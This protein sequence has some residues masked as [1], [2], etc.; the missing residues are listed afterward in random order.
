MF[1][2]N[3]FLLLV[4]SCFWAHAGWTQEL[5]F[6]SEP[7]RY[8]DKIEEPQA[9]GKGTTQ[10]GTGSEAAQKRKFELHGMI[11]TQ[12]RYNNVTGGTAGSLKDEGLFHA[13]TLRLDLEAEVAENTYLRVEAIGSFDNQASAAASE[14]NLDFFNC[15]FFRPEVFDFQVGDIRPYLSYFTL[16]RSL[17]GGMGSYRFSLGGE[18]AL[19]IM[20]VG[21]QVPM[22][23]G[24]GAHRTVTGYR[25]EGQE[26]LPGLV[27]GIDQ[28]FIDDRDDTLPETDVSVVSLNGHWDIPYIKNA[29]MYWDLAHS[30]NLQDSGANV[31]SRQDGWAVRWGA[32]YAPVERSQLMVEY[33]EASHDFTSPLASG[34]PD[35][36]MV[37]FNGSYTIFDNLDAGAGYTFVRNNL[38]GQ[39]DQAT[40]SHQPFTFVAYRPFHQHTAE[41]LANL[42]L[43]QHIIYTKR[44]DNT[45]DS[46]LWDFSWSIGTR[47]G[48]LQPR[49]DY[50]LSLVRDSGPDGTDRNTHTLGVDL[51]YQESFWDG[52]VELDAG[53]YFR[54]MDEQIKTPGGQRNITRTTGCRF[55]SRLYQHYEITGKFEYQRT[56]TA[57]GA[58]EGELYLFEGGAS[59]AHTL[60]YG[61][62]Q[63]GFTI[64][65]DL[66]N[67]RRNDFDELRLMATVAY[68]F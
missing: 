7:V 42:E 64:N 25:L 11:K 52:A 14:F 9:T 16:Q 34:A 67:Y 62:M 55:L 59:Y 56:D 27:V 44:Y 3:F 46:Q 48:P 54:Y 40:R 12:V 26:L 41:V 33:E 17:E 49:F 57:T 5:T 47:I 22:D 61:E 1:R 30:F 28:T 20:A 45:I 63:A 18:K 35:R 68:V 50:S 66:Y 43:S 37:R 31:P 39:L 29:Q 10:A 23:F 38:H 65:Y 51:G 32:R 58:F 24:G 19:R 36:R 53:V 6:T 13:H 60:P 15:Q 21:G 4:W 8:V 2:R